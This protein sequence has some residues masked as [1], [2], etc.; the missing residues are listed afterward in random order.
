MRWSRSGAEVIEIEVVY[1]RA[2]TPVIEAMKLAVG[3]TLGE[4][5]E[6]SGF[7]DRFPEISLATCTVGIFG[8]VKRLEDEAH[9]GDRIEIYV[10]L[11]MDPKDR[12]RHLSRR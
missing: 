10:P 4:A 11:P 1:A 5:V 7:L 3:T 2:R 6:R 9:D 12:R 8:K